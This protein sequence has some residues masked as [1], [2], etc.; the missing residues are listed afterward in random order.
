MV[1]R[2]K[3]AAAWFWRELP[4]IRHLVRPIYVNL[5]ILPEVATG[6]QSAAEMRENQ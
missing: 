2:L 6:L 1:H 4:N 5:G 3:I